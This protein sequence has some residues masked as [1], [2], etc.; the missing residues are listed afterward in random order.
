MITTIDLGGT[1]TKFGLVQ[2]GNV[3]ASS[4]CDAD[5]GGSLAAHLKELSPR[6]ESLLQKS[7]HQLADCSGVGI[8]ST[9]LVDSD[10]MRV[11]YPGD[12]YIDAV[13][14]DFKAWAESEYDLPLKLLNDAKAALLGEWL[15]GAAQGYENV[16]MLTLGTGIGTAALVDGHLLKG[17]HHCGGNLGGHIIVNPNGRP[18]SCGGRGCMESEASGW[19]LPQLLREHPAYDQSSLKGLSKLGFR[20]MNEHADAGDLAAREIRDHC[21]ST[22]GRGITSLIHVLSPD[23]VVIGGGLMNDAEPVIAHFA[24]TIKQHAWPGF[25][26]TPLIKAAQP[27]N[28]ALLGAASLF[29]HT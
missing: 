22:W 2:D 15:H 13:D 24:Q 14:F 4:H 10:R 20:E 17:K 6:L 19:V 28:A 18:C 9:G 3:L 12:K 26:N 16:L 25:K 5:S 8:S 1:R 23:I 11:L 29:S 7:G 21:L 27:D